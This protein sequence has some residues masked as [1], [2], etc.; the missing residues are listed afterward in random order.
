VADIGT[1]TGIEFG[2]NKDGTA[3]VRL[4]QVQ[5]SEESDIQTVEHFRQPGDDT[6]P[7]VGDKVVIF[8]IGES[9][10]IA[11]SADDLV[12]PDVVEGAKK[13]YSRD[14]AGAISA[15][16]NFLVTGELE[17][18]GNADFAVAFNDLETEF[19]KLRDAWDAFANNY[20]P[21][22]PTVQGTPASASASGAD[23]SGAKV[24][25]VKLP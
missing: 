25:N 8:D 6:S 3:D 10:K 11:V 5:I 22:S 7:I 24:A 14:A 12:I 13:I 23:L 17:L 19:N 15:F 9:W 18:N 2:K 1:I 20:V 21:G 16:I 4:L